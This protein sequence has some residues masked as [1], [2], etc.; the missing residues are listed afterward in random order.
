MEGDR[1]YNC[2]TMPIAWGLNA[3]KVFVAVWLIVLIAV[4]AILQLYVV[5]FG[6]WASIS[7]C[8]LF[9]IVPLVWILLRLFK[10]HTQADFHR[11]S[12]VVKLV[13]LT[14]ILSMGF[15]RIYY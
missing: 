7:Y 9:I 8:V 5:P 11:L 10:A 3:T 4:L 12:V 15:F 6:W 1:K 13:M 2:H 14:G